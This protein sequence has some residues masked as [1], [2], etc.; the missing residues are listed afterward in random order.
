MNTSH[1]IMNK[2]H[3]PF[4]YTSKGFFVCSYLNNTHFHHVTSACSPWGAGN[5]KEDKQ[6]RYTAKCLLS[7]KIG[8]KY[9]FKPWTL[10]LL[11]FMIDGLC[12]Y[13]Y[14][15]LANPASEPSR[16]G[17]MFCSG[18]QARTFMLPGNR[19]ANKVQF[20]FTLFQYYLRSP[21]Y[22]QNSR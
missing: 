11:T 13:L 22:N 18:F 19:R 21:L 1:T 6:N 12:L 15:K 7:P 5:K 2:S 20:I 14:W 16:T 9:I 4:T 8:L 3:T 10:L 17:D